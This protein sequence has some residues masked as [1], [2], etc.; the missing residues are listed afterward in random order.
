MLDTTNRKGCFFFGK[1][2][3][4]EAINAMFEDNM[5]DCALIPLLNLIF[6]SDQFYLYQ[7]KPYLM[8]LKE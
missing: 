8:L 7:M 6:H 1:N 5:G 4:R 3:K 2:Q